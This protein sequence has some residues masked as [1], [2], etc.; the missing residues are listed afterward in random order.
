MSN[1]R[2]QGL[3]TNTIILL[4]LG[5]II[6]VLLIVGFMTGWKPFKNLLSPSNVDSVVED[7]QTV[8][9]LGQKYNFCSAERT[10]RSNEDN[11]EDT[12]SCATFSVFSKYE[13][14]AIESCPSISCDFDCAS[15][16]SGGTLKSECD[17]L[18]E[19]EV[20]SIAQ[21]EAGMKCCIPKVA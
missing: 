5:V 17:E 4:I 20:T 16:A 10:L 6:L 13:K 18:T 19:D 12:A 1:K 14:Y 8:C 15:I 9:A 3:S 2:G 11:L 7:C 21:V